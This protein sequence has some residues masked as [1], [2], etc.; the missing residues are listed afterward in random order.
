MPNFS[1]QSLTT[2]GQVRS[3]VLTANDRAEVVRQLLT[4]GETATSVNLADAKP[5]AR[6]GVA[7]GS[8]FKSPKSQASASSVLTMSLGARRGRPSISRADMAQL[9]RE[10]ATA[11]EAGLPMMSSLK[12]VRKQAPGKA[13]PVIL[14]HLIERVEAGD[15]L[16]TAARDY[17]PPFDNMIV[18][19]LRAADA[20]RKMSEVLHQLSDLLERSL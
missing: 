3:G 19:M 1:Y 11:L 4:R 10:L 6:N 16:H 14:D 5:A 9:M 7:T 18:G 15:P 13:L 8:T 17:G 20:S 12:T 2:N